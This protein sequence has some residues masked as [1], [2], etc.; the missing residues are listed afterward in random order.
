MEFRYKKRLA[1]ANVTA[2][3]YHQCRLRNIECYLEYVINRCVF[4]AVIVKNGNIVCCV[5]VKNYVRSQFLNTDT[6]QIFK[7]LKVGL[8]L[9]W[10]VN[11]SQVPIVLDEIEA[12]I[13]ERGV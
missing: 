13:K 11:M 1:E 8:P 12:F 6:W 7:Y 3:F 5:E 4:D 9:F 2:E 10:V